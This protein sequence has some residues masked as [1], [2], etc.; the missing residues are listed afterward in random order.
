MERSPLREPAGAELWL[1]GAAE[2]PEE[3]PPPLEHAAAPTASRSARA[4]VEGLICM[5]VTFSPEAGSNV[6]TGAAGRPRRPEL[7]RVGGA[8]VGPDG[9]TGRRR[10]GG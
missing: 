5:V 4:T 7:V 9:S 8:G 10:R 6:C 1:D 3:L 2:A